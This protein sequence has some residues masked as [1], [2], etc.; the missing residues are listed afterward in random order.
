MINFDNIT[1]EKIKEHNPNWAQI[2]DHP[3]RILIIGGFGF[4]KTV[5][6]FNLM[7][8]Q[9]DI[10]KIQLYAKELQDLKIIRKISVF[11]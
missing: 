1:K 3:S 6:L 5:S 11:I 2:P 8:Q 9:P 10:H 4:G 7:S